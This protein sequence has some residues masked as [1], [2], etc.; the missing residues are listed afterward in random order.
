MHRRV[1]C[2]SSIAVSTKV[3]LRRWLAGTQAPLGVR[4][5]LSIFLLAGPGEHS[6]EPTL[7]DASPGVVRSP[8]CQAALPFWFF[9]CTHS[10]TLYFCSLSQECTVRGGRDAKLQMVPLI[11]STAYTSR[12]ADEVG[13]ALEAHRLMQL[14]HVPVWRTTGVASGARAGD[15]SRALRPRKRQDVT[16]LD[17]M[18]G[19]CRR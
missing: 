5:C 14:S 16:W 12:A 15:N 3:L 1:E 7:W 19:V 6:I 9:S 11:T 13:A 17:V 18:R 8:A 2:L 10:L 4:C